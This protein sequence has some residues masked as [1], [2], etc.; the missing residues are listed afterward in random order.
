MGR[1]VPEL[2][3]DDSQHAELRA[4]TRRATSSQAV[5]L[6]ARIVLRCADGLANGE[7]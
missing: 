6:R 5:A 2:V 7:V 1:P 3:L 4:W